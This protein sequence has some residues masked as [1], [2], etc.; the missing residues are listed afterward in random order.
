VCCVL[1]EFCES[2][3][4]L[5]WRRSWGVAGVNAASPDFMTAAVEREVSDSHF[6]SIFFDV[7]S[8][9]QSA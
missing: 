4:A 8:M 6:F 3:L 2:V 5:E 1:F 9:G 7:S